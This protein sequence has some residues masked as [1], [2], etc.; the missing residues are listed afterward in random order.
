MKVNTLLFADY[1]FYHHGETEETVIRAIG[2]APPSALRW[3]V[4]TVAPITYFGELWALRQ[5]TQSEKSE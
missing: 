3:Y 1:R 2:C 5:Y 4:Q